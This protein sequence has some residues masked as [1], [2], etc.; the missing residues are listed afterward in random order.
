MKIQKTGSPV[1]MGNMTRV[2]GLTPRF[3]PRPG[4][5]DLYKGEGVASGVLDGQYLIGKRQEIIVVIE[6]LDGQRIVL[7]KDVKGKFRLGHNS[8]YTYPG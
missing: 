4:V 7:N 1:S 3:S 6:K 5:S 2:D 8:T